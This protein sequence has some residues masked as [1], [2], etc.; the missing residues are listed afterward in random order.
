[1]LPA[2]VRLTVCPMASTV[3]VPPTCS[4]WPAS[5]DTAPRAVKL[6]LPVTKVSPNTSAS[7][8][9]TRLAAVPLTASA[10][11]AVSF[12][13]PVSRTTDSALLSESVVSPAVTCSVPVKSFP[14]PVA[15][16]AFR[17]VLARVALSPLTTPL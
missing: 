5:W 9:V 14:L 17:A 2:S 11:P 7:E 12:V 6:P 1:M 15:A 10:W 13:A 3:V 4:A 16:I 8:S